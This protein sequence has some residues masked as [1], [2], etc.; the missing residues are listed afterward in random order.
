MATL[1]ERF[2]WP[3]LWNDVRHHVRSCF[4]CQVRSVRKVQVPL[5]VS[6]PA[7]IFVKIYLDIMYMPTVQGYRYIVAARDDLSG[8]AEGRALRKATSSAVAKFLWEEIFCRY[9]HFIIRESLVKLC[10]GK[11]R[12]W[13]GYVQQA[14]FADKIT[15]RRQTGFSP[16][17][18]LHGIYP[19]LPFD[20]AEASFMVDGFK[21]GMSSEELLTLRIRQLEKKPE[22]LAKASEVLQKHRFRSKDQFEQ[23][24]RTRMFRDSYT[25]GTLVLVRNSHVEASLDRKTKDRYMGPYEVVRQTRNGAYVLQELDGTPWRQAVAAFRLIPYISRSDKYLDQILGRIQPTSNE[26]SSSSDSSETDSEEAS[27][28]PRILT[29]RMALEQGSISSSLSESEEDSEV[30]DEED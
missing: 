3:S 18:L 1:K 10:D 23:R 6:T 14:F 21:S 16:F 22:D 19:V 30:H 11:I 13:P 5:M 17:Y 27:N 15:V 29:R 2:Y 7:T 12:R 26:D 8:A 9:G 25:P 4:Q 20:L 28:P 24:Y